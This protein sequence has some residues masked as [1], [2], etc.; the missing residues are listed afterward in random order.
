MLSITLLI[1]LFTTLVSISAFG[2]PTV[3]DQFIFDPVTI[4][5]RQQW[6]RFFTCGLIHAD[7]EHLLFNMLSLFLFGQMVESAFQSDILFGEQGKLFYALLYLSAL[8]LSLV[9][10]FWQEREN[11]YYRS[12]GASG[13]VSAIVFVGILFNPTAKIGL[14]LIPPI[15]PGYIFGPLYLLLSAWLGKRGGD[16]INH[17]AHI[18]GAIAGV[19][20]TCLICWWPQ[21]DY[22]PW[23]QFIVKV[24]G[25]F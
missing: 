21:T 15:I 12:L 5:R 23:Q 10:T 20:L 6:Y 11:R 3:I 17:S 4:N 22:Q 16:Q 24:K 18:S 2:K 19:V 25:E 8:F 1:V 7:W 13:A 14:F 9:P